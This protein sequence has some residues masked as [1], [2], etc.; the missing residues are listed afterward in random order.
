MG[1][2][3]TT[4]AG[5]LPKERELKEEAETRDARQG[6][7]SERMEGDDEEESREGG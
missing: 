7:E 2:I 6:M 1:F 3:A 5:R 4:R